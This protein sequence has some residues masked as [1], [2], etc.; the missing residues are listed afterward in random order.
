MHDNEPLAEGASGALL[1][2]IVAQGPDAMIVSDRDG[3]VRLWNPAAERI[4]G[5]SA[6]Q[7]RAGGMDLIIPERFRQAHWDA[8]RRAVATGVSKYAGKP[9]TTRAQRADGATI[10]VDL[11]FALL[12]GDDGQVFA[13]LATARECTER[14]L[15]AREAARRLAALEAQAPKR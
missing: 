1:A 11:G 13:V 9:L 5:F 3:G 7:A 8:F 14:Y 4:F 12:K 2:A 15:A 10:Y 6:E